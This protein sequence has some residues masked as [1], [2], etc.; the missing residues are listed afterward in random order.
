[1]GSLDIN[2]ENQNLSQSR[3]GTYYMFC[4]HRLSNVGKLCIK[5][6][7]HAPQ[8]LGEKSTYPNV[9]RDGHRVNS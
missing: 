2:F 3:F 5:S 6:A 4:L 9:R 1:M 7:L 8:T